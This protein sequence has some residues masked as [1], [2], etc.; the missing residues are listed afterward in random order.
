MKDIGV[1]G[2]P[3]KGITTEHGRSS[4]ITNF[5]VPVLVRDI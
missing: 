4:D 2:N 5:R 3:L 1:F